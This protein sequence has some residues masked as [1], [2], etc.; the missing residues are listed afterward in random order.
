MESC[1]DVCVLCKRNGGQMN[2]LGD[3][4]L[5]T[6]IRVSIEKEDHYLLEKLTELQQSQCPVHVHHDCRRK[7]VDLRKVP[8]SLPQ[9][10]KLRSST[11]TIFRWESCCF[12]CA[13]PIDMRHKKRDR[14]HQVCTLPIHESLIECAREER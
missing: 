13:K 3:K 4:G 6:M 8:N 1:Q 2:L 12:L 7:F 5:N 10:K 9:S 14:I 11:E